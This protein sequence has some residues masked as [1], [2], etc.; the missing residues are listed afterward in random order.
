[1]ENKFTKGNWYISKTVPYG[2]GDCYHIQSDINTDETFIGEVGGGLQDNAQV[3]ANAKL[4]AA[5]PDLFKAL[6]MA[7]YEM[8]DWHE[9][10][11]NQIDSFDNNGTNNER[12]MQSDIANSIYEKL[13]I[14]KAAIKKAQ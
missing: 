3:E 2:D 5:A 9:Y 6:E 4:I 13:Q 12:D 7:M 1:M 10:N 14:I 11:Y 8:K